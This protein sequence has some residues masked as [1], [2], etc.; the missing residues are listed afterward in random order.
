MIKKILVPTDFSPIADNATDYA[1]E[2]AAEFKSELFL[3]HVYTLD[4][5]NYD[6]NF[7]EDEQPYT[8]Q[9]KRN[10]NRT[11]L[12]FMEKITQKGL[13]IQTRV[14]QDDIFSLFRR[15][16]DE[17]GINLIVMGSQGA[18]GLTKVIFGSVAA[19]A[20]DMAKVPLLVVPPEHTFRHFKN[21]VFAIDQRE[22]APD[23]LSPLQELAVKFGAKVT[24]L[25]V[26]TDSNKN[27]DRVSDLYLDGVETT[28]REVPM[29]NSINETINQFIQKEGCDL[30]C[31]IRREK[32]FL[33]SIF[34]KSITKAQVYNNQ[35]PLLVLPEV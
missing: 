33:K 17:H 11:K 20:L 13:S 26:Y 25:N 12:K 35:V 6:L 3:Y 22:V 14:E 7:H 29:S 9:V 16:V 5:F 34:Q 28:F 18:S 24:I 32:G 8:Q 10:M 31:M 1:I 19:S 15:K 27:T 30:L 4:R 2:I 21:I 23:L